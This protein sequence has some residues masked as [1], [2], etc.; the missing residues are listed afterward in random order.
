MTIW[1]QI[2]IFYVIGAV[3][4]GGFVSAMDKVN[5]SFRGR[6]LPYARVVAGIVSG[7]IW[8]AVVWQIIMP[9]HP[10]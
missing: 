9:R 6:P 1:T 5:F 7:A 4:I 8:P 2:A 3:I 10:Q